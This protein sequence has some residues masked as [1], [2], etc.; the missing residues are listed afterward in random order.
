M[1][2]K[3]VLITSVMLLGVLAGLVFWLMVN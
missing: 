1:R 3:I 2:L